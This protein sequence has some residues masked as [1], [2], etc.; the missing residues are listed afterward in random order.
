MAERSIL[1]LGNPLLWTPS[2]RIADPAHG[3][4]Q[5]VI[6]DL[7]DTLTRFRADTGWGRAPVP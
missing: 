1:R 5:E 6:R 3:Y 4:V 2:G 7:G